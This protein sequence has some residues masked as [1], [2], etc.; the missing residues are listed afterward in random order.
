MDDLKWQTILKIILDGVFDT[1]VLWLYDYTT[2][3][4]IYVLNQPVPTYK[5]GVDRLTVMNNNLTT[6]NA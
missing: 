1:S 2:A 6:K 3:R 4:K 5:T